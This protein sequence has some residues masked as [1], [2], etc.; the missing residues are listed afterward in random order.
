MTAP[1][2]ASPAQLARMSWHQ[3]TKYQR[4][5]RAWLDTDA[6]QHAQRRAA[7]PATDNDRATILLR[8]I[9]AGLDEA[10]RDHD[11]GRRFE[12]ARWLAPCGTT[13]AYRRHLRYGEKCDPCREAANTHRKTYPRRRAV[14]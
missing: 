14:A 1:P 9:I 5:I 11:N 6:E 3:R 7:N 13:S 10:T 4:R 12:Q 8:S 2:I